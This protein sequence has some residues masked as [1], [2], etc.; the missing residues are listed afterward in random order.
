M[1]EGRVIVNFSRHVLVEEDSG[2]RLDC[3]LRG[4]KL[5][6]VCGDRV[7]F[8]VQGT[9]YG[10]IEEVLPRR[11]VLVRHDQR[12]PLA[13]LAANLDRM[14]VVA[15]PEPEFDAWLL[16]KYLVAAH[17][18]AI[19]PVVVLNK[20]DLIGA[21][22][23]LHA[24]LAE[25]AALGLATL[26]VSA[27]SALGIDAFRS[28]LVG[29]TGIVVGASGT[30]KSSLVKSVVPG[31]ELA[32]AAISRATGEGKH[33]TTRSMLFKLPGGGELIDSPGVRDFHLWPMP[34]RELRSHFVEFRPLAADCKFTDCTHRTEPQC[35]VSAA[36][37]DGRILQR[38]Y[39]S[40][41][42]LARIMDAQF[43]SWEK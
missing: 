23:P 24:A 10:I 28:A 27:R 16:D 42:G 39:D 36:V 41:L 29:R 1:R 43:V 4:R 38:R 15:A 40:Y 6:A 20:C 12:K 18:L 26:A 21:D 35:A 34:V 14:F 11:S 32:V 5:S 13:P 2:A 30:G 8:R 7:R 25:Y 31:L 19:E 37:G 22:D 9:G 33:T 3:Q 17:A